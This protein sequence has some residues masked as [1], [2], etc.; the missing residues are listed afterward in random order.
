GRVAL[1]GARQSTRA[2][3]A[4]FRR[5]GFLDFLW[6]TKY[7]TTD[8]QIAYIAKRV[9][10][11]TNPDFTAWEAGN[12]AKTWWG[13]NGTD[14]RK[15]ARYSGQYN[16]GSGWV[17]WGP[18]P[19]ADVAWAPGDAIN[20]PVHSKDSLLICGNPSFGQSAADRIETEAPVGQGLRNAGPAPGEALWS[21]PNAYGPVMN[22]TLKEAADPMD[23]PPSNGALAS[24]VSPCCHF[25]GKTRI[26][27]NSDGSMTVKNPA[28]GLDDAPMTQPAN[29]VIYVSNDTTSSCPAYNPANTD[30][31]PDACGTLRV[32]GTYTQNMTLAAENDI[33]VTGDLEYASGSTALLGLIAQKYAR[34]WHPTGTTTAQWY[35]TAS[36]AATFNAAGQCNS[37]DTGA[38][39]TIEIDAA[40][41]TIDHSFLVDNWTCGSVRR[42][43][44]KVVGAI[45]QAFRGPVAGASSGYQK[46]Y[47]YD[48]RLK[49][50]AP[51]NFLNPV[52]AAWRVV[53]VS[54]QAGA[55]NIQGT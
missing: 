33:V 49:Y 8:P 3:V 17:N 22:G 29:G 12:C 48:T 45:A 27:F 2:I 44:L 10:W 13:T 25:V 39:A 7:E 53:R 46:N 4:T 47:I 37:G 34:V 18:T 1:N 41:L 54:E 19:C 36:G 52:Q 9:P 38:L 20:G 51:P 35:G 14:G 40:I 55:V 6:Y 23:M 5:R 16:P 28:M 32:K 26:Q 50:R 31:A 21:C 24:V 30:A 15:L 43:E 42:V 11:P